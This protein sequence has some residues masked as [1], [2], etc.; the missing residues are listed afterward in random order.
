VW[1]CVEVCGSVWKCVEVCC[2]VSLVWDLLAQS[3]PIHKCCRVAACC[4]VLQ[5]VAVYLEFDTH[6]HVYYSE[7][8]TSL[9]VLQCV[10]VAVRCSLWVLNVCCNDTILL[11]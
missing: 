10:C 5:C 11:Q 9:L 8:E 4:S 3:T 2:S 1:K 6:L 7:C